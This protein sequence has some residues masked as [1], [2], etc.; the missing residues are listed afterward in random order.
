MIALAS[1]A[2]FANTMHCESSNLNATG[3]R[4]SIARFV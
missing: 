4:S 3:D 1:A 2:L